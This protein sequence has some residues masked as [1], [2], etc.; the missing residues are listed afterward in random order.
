MP[1]PIR[2]SSR[3]ASCLVALALVACAS[4][5]G[6]PS[7]PDTVAPNPQLH[8]EGVPPVPRSLVAAVDRY[9]DFRGHVFV[10]WHPARREML[11]AHRAAGA[12]T[13]QLFRV[14]S[15]LAEPERL[16]DSAEPVTSGQYEPR[17]GHY[18]VFERATGGNE[19]SQLYR[20]DLDSKAT[21]LLTDPDRP[22]HSG[23]RS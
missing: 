7:A 2:H 13:P 17:D 10:D 21:T 14:G 4:G 23:A 15:P 19:V 12:S 11:V 9:T 3:L 6:T 20:M 16:T 18:I 1:N 22:L 5:P 8:V